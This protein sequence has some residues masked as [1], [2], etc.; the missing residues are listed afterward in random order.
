MMPGTVELRRRRVYKVVRGIFCQT[1]DQG[2]FR[3]CQYSVQHNHIHLIIEAS[4][5]A[6]MTRGMR[7]VNIRLGKQLNKAMGRR[8]GRVIADRY[9]EVHLESPTQ[10]RNALA[11]VLNNYRKHLWRE[12]GERCGAGWVDSC[13]SAEFFDGWRGRGAIAP[14][15]GDP[16][17]APR[18]GLLKQVWRRRGLI[19]LNEVPG[20]RG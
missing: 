9:H 4:D 6:A 2:R 18:T 8:K 13:S 17:A 12:R 1:A 20:P 7:R 15:R 19:A 10:V 14:S 3:I 16:V 5:R 11:Y